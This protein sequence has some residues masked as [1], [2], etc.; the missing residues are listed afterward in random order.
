VDHVTTLGYEPADMHYTGSCSCGA[1]CR[2]FTW[3]HALAWRNRHDPASARPQDGPYPSWQVP[4]LCH[5]SATA[6]PRHEPRP[7]EYWYLASNGYWFAQCTEC[8]AV[9]R[10]YSDLAPLRVCTA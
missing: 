4:G 10:R 3:D 5:S 8:C 7:G 1:G 2:L 6:R 9:A